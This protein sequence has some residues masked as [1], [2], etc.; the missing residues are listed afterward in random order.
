MTKSARVSPPNSI[1]LLVDRE[2]AEI[3][4]SLGD[5]LVSNTDTCAVIGTFNA[6]DGDTLI[7]L[8]NEKPINRQ[9]EYVA[10]TGELQFPSGRASVCTVDDEVLL[11]VP[12]PG[13]VAFVTILA[14]DRSE[15]S[16][17]LVCVSSPNKEVRS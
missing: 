17:I 2:A 4:E 13:N 9:L 15:P 10:F 12:V 7:T 14:N 1:V 11:E 8:T 16:E 6:S 3:P 5:E